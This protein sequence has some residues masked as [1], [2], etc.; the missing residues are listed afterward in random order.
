MTNVG[1]GGERR[2]KYVV[3]FR[4]LGRGAA[5]E[6]QI[7]SQ[8]TADD[9]R[10]VAPGFRGQAFDEGWCCAKY[11]RCASGLQQTG[12]AID[13]QVK[14]QE[15][16]FGPIFV[17]ELIADENSRLTAEPAAKDVFAGVT[18]FELVPV[19]HRAELSAIVAELLAGGALP[20]IDAEPLGIGVVADMA[21]LDD[22]E[23]FAVMGMRS[24]PI[25]RNV[26][27]DQAVVERKGSEVLGD[28]ND[29]I[30]LT[31]V[32]AKRARRH[33]SFA[34][35]SHRQAIIVQPWNELAV[36][37]RVAV[38]LQILD[39]TLHQARPWSRCDGNNDR[40]SQCD[41]SMRC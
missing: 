5:E 3:A 2:L 9:L 41:R 36:A 20:L 26:A 6:E 23:I 8:V 17:K 18:I 25:E 12:A 1:G 11:I 7:G 15:Q 22:D 37:H 32:G 28:Q 29:R 19:Q 14:V 39:E 35:E 34:A 13:Q 38:E 30:A 40:T 24:V 33:H 10:L 16:A 31:L 27:A 4:S 21:C